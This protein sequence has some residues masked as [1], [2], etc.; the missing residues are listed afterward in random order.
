MARGTF[1]Q[2]PL[3]EVEA[4]NGVKKYLD[5]KIGTGYEVT[6]YT[7]KGKTIFITIDFG[8]DEVFDLV[9]NRRIGDNGNYRIVSGW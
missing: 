9:I 4:L 5:K 6:Q 8:D 1:I 7:D 2:K 3:D